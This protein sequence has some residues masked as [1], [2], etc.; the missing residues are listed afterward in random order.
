MLFAVLMPA[1]SLAGIGTRALRNRA[2]Y[3]ILAVLVVT[4]LAAAS[5]AHYQGVFYFVSDES[6]AVSGFLERAESGSLVLDGFF[7][8]PVWLDPDNRT[9]WTRLVFQEIYPNDLEEVSGDIVY[10]VTDPTAELWYRQWRGVEIYRFYEGRLPDY[11]LIYTNG[12]ADIFL[13]RSPPTGG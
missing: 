13:I 12:Q 6:V 8:V 7:P 11:S 5:T 3:G 9:P 1:I 2:R 10:A 4:S